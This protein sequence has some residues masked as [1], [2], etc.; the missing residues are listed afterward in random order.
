MTHISRR[1]FLKL[2]GIGLASAVIPESSYL[3]SPGLE[4]PPNVII[5]LC[6][7][8]SASHLSLHGYPRLT[9]PSMDAFAGQ[10]IVYHNHYSDSNFTTTGVASMLTG[11]HAWKHR[12]I[13]FGGL[14]NAGRLPVN[15]YTLLGKEYQRLAFSQNIWPDRLLGQ[16]HEDIDR[17]LAPNSF[18]RLTS[19][20][21]A[22][23][24]FDN[25]PTLTSIAVSEFLL[26]AQG[27]SPTGSSVLG[28]IYKDNYLKAVSRHVNVNYPK[29]LPEVQMSNGYVIP[30]LNEEV[31][32]G[33]YNEINALGKGHSPYL[34]YFHLY[35][36]HSPYRPHSRYRYLF[37]DDYQPVPKPRHHYSENL[38]ENLMLTQ[39][40]LYDR[41]IAH[42]D[43]EFGKLITRLEENG[44]LDT[45]YVIL[46]SDHGELFER[47]FI[48]HGTQLMYEPVIRIPLLIH[49]PRQTARQDVF[50]L[51]SNIDILPTLLSV[52]GRDVPAEVDGRLLPGLGGAVDDD[53][54]IFS[55]L[56]N[57]N[58]AF[59]PI[60]KAV[61]S[62]RKRSHKIIAYLGYEG[63]DQVYE[64][65]DLENDPEELVDLSSRDSGKLKSLKEELLDN[66]EKANSSS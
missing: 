37:R 30:Y 66:L 46:T 29:G 35:S 36:P 55:I 48:G 5:I 4:K 10:S 17:F 11:M 65:Y 40:T 28:Q 21:V 23:R 53:R 51:T 47:G 3:Q 22:G 32:W 1:D 38:T 31:F 57:E 39:R 60:K 20:P 14:I 34:A 13:N 61:I 25:D 49:A 44:T 43:R 12:A 18:S 7:A 41:Q 50:S 64:L 6:D 63:F 58:S 54:P 19:S 59:A 8:L 15:P 33:L 26:S 24:R 2:A 9:T 62:M 42:I 27:K 52:A 16:F 56:A 45:S